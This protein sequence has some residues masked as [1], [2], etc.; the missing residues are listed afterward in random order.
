MKKPSEY[1]VDEVCTFLNAIGLGSKIGAFQENAIDGGMLVS[2]TDEDLQNDLGL[3]SL[4]ARKFLQKMEFANDISEGGGG[5][6]D[7]EAAGIIAFLE[8]ENDK[9]QKQVK[10]LQDVV[11]ALSGPQTAPAPAPKPKPA[12]AP[13]PPPPKKKEH[14]VVKEGARGAARG[15]VL[16]AIGGAIAG[17]AGKGAKM[18]AAMG[19]T[20][21]GMRGIRARRGRR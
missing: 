18:G 12:P 7:P 9:L 10:E 17:D 19:G 14:H 21:G 11:T 20:A 13:A 5:G 15:A 8:E 4:Q 3:S 1:T 16:G 6:G 2:L